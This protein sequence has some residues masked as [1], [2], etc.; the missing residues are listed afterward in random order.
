[1]ATA[2]EA[3]RGRQ[4]LDSRGRPTVEAECRL[5]GGV[6]GRGIV[7]SGA[8]TGENE[9]IE[10]RDGGSEWDGKAVTGAVRNVNDRI[11]GAI[12]G[13]DARDQQGVDRTLIELDGTPNK[14]ALGAN[15]ILAVSPAP[16]SCRRP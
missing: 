12:A 1:M 8:S 6:V 5:S 14:S 3:I 2:I 4:V 10:L 15:A 13:M 11:A 16:A 9:A 7:P